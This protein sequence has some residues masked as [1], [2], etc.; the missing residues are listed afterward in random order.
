MSCWF[1]R[2]HTVAQILAACAKHAQ[3]TFLTASF[4]EHFLIFC[5]WLL[6]PE[7]ICQGFGL[8]RDKHANW[9]MFSLAESQHHKKFWRAR[10]RDRVCLVFRIIFIINV[11]NLFIQML[12]HILAARSINNFH[13]ESWC[14]FPFNIASNGLMRPFKYNWL[15][16]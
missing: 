15:V 7:R 4:E 6:K 10:E 2:M 8:M 1:P 11:L 5:V 9:F 13:I 16:D 14:V 12:W 3:V